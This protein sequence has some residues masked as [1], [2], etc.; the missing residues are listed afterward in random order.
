MRRF[1]GV[2]VCVMLAVGLFAYAVP[3]KAATQEHWATK[4]V[5][6]MTCDGVNALARRE[7]WD[8][9]ITAADFVKGL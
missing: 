2:F 1:L 7:D 9:E 4:Y 5:S 6:E 8:Y 3:A